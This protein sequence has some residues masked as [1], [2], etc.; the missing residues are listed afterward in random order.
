MSRDVKHYG[1]K[2]KGLACPKCAC[3]MF[4]TEYTKARDWGIR[5]GKKC[6]NCGH[7][8][9]TKETIDYK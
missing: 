2:D 1:P 7:T 4:T 6:R 9:M 5:R 3:R 8:I